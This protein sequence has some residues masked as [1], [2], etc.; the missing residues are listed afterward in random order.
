MYRFLLCRIF[1]GRMVGAIEYDNPEI[2]VWAYNL[3]KS[4]DA[5]C[6]IR[7]ILH[8]AVVRDLLYVLKLF[9]E[10]DPKNFDMERCYR[11]VIQYRKLKILEWIIS[12]GY[13]AGYQTY[14]NLVC[15]I[16]VN[17]LKWVRTNDPNWNSE[18]CYK[19]AIDGKSKG[20]LTDDI[21]HWFE[22]HDID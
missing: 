16:G 13:I 20:K 12:T 17:T 8:D 7:D 3:I 11:E 6:T 9:R 4:D 5:N 18:L 1:T 21:I 19:A 2:F 14:C 10:V 22:N 15:W